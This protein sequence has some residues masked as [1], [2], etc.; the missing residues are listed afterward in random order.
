MK[1]NN[2]QCSLYVTRQLFCKM[3]HLDELTP[4]NLPPEIA[5]EKGNMSKGLHNSQRIVVK[6]KCLVGIAFQVFVV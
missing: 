4:A 3:T 1:Y 6:K 2:E 5:E